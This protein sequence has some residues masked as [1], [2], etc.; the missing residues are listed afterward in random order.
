MK[1]K[2]LSL[3]YIFLIGFV[4]LTLIFTEIG[5]S[6]L[7][8][9]LEEYE[10][11]QYK[12]V[13]EEVLES[14]FNSGNGETL[15]QLFKAQISEVETPE[16]A[17][18]YFDEI[19]A[20]NTFSL[21]ST[22]TGLDKK[23][24]YAVKCNDK[25]FATLTFDKSGAKTKNGFALYEL[26]SA[27]LND[28]L[29]IERSV[30]VPVGYT[31]FVNGTEVGSEFALG[32][33]FKTSLDDEMPG[34]I[35]G[36]EYVTYVVG[37]LLGEPDI[38]VVSPAGNEAKI[39]LVKDGIYC[40]EIVFDK[41][42][43]NELFDYVIDATEAYACY[44]QKDA[45]FGTVAKYLDKTSELYT[46]IRTSPNWMVISHN[47]YLFEDAEVSEYYEYDEDTFSCRVK[48][49]HVLKYRGLQDYRDYIDITWYLKKSNGKFF[50]YDSFNNN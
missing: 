15:Y 22:S 8:D 33:V 38:K 42:I 3:F 27:K 46:S 16:G 1:T 6:Y 40:A 36:V 2:K 47:S 23:I 26:T 12:Y 14:N 13:A 9:V 44:L 7:R 35:A 41:T 29:F 10:N 19:V 45:V 11:S 48:L 37:G 17:K 4:V 34:N 43:S 30:F 18:A 49:T 20:E 32:E 31:L 50:I 39:S 5:K 24:E 28:K 25:R 21:Q